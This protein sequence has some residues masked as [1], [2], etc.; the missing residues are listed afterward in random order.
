LIFTYIFSCITTGK[1]EAQSTCDCWQQRDTSFHVVPFVGYRAP[2]Y[3]ND[4]GSSPLIILPFKFCFWGRQV[5]SL[6]INNNGN[7]TFDQPLSQFSA[8]TF[9]Y[10]NNIPMIAAFWADVDTYPGNPSYPSSD[11]VYYQVTSTHLIVQ[12]DSVG[13]VGPLWC[14]SH[15]NGYGD[16]DTTNTFEI[17]ITNGNDPILP[18]G[19]NVEICYKNMQWTTGA[20]SP[21]PDCTGHDHGFGGDPGNV[22]ANEG[23]GIRS[24]QIGLFD[25]NT[26]NYAGQFPPAPYY[27]G[28]YWLTNKSFLFNLCSGTIAPLTSGISPCDT[29][30]VCLGDSIFIPLYFLS[31]LQ[32]DSV[33]SNLAP[34]IPT[35]VSIISNKPGPTDSLT[36]RVIGSSSSYGYHII[37]VYGYDNQHPPDTTYVSF[38]VEVDSAPHVHLTALRDTICLGDSSLLTAYGGN[39]YSWSTGSTS[40]SIKVAPTMSQT[41]TVGISNGG[42]FKDTMINVVVLTMPTLTVIARP[43]S[44]CSKDSV[45]LIANGGNSYKWSTGQ[46]KDSIWVNPDST[47]TYRLSS[48][49]GICSDSTSISVF[50][51]AAGKTTLTHSTD[52]LCPKGTFTITA[53]GGNSYL[54]SN[55]S[56]TSSIVVNPDSTTTYTVYS[57]VLCAIDTLK[58]KVVIIPLPKPV[59]KGTNWKC[60]GIK[61]TLTVTGGASYLWNNGTTNTIYYTGNIDADSMVTVVAFNSLGCPDTT[62]FNITL[63]GT[64]TVTITPPTITCANNPVVLNANATGTGSLSYKWSP[65]GETSS[66]ITVTDSIT[67]TYTVLVSNGCLKAASVTVTPMN[68]PLAACCD[69]TILTGDDTIIGSFGKGLI[70]YTWSPPVICKNPICDTVIVNPGITTTYT[71]TGT[72]SDGCQVERVV[73]IVV[74]TPCF[75]FTVP[76][77]FTPDNPGPLGLNGLFYIKTSNLSSWSILIY[78][79]W[80]KEMFKSTNPLQYWGGAT[81]SGAKAPDGVYYYIINATCQGTNYKRDGFLQLIR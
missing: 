40:S 6:F 70:S 11:A 38:V 16:Y 36:V 48:S 60:F 4:D 9:P 12:W 10:N 13:F 27:D 67:T 35:G 3:R 25:T 24:L 51:K 74:E 30:K 69:K 80:G 28:V 75:N 19:N 1:V 65:G 54:W 8:D 77:V 63:R 47:K 20:D 43:D 81:E 18:K 66:S 50:V 58:Q 7:I 15:P 59:I 37:N 55:G 33:W 53:N 34:P 46:T 72:D 26:A 2:Y 45:L 5:D 22:G 49:N 76:N 44:I 32:G 17:I 29:F 68:P 71:V 57:N 41:Y 56:T 23:D 52:T 31:P 78:D 42:C 61:D 73:T 64:P 39:I 79:R 62:Q 21:A 14:V